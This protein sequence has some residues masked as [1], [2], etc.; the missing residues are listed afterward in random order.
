MVE[1]ESEQQ[2]QERELLENTVQNLQSKVRLY[3]SAEIC[4]KDE[5]STLQGQVRQQ[6]A[7]M[8]RKDEDLFNLQRQ[9]S[10]YERDV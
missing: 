6:E 7:Q 5:I 9:N 3:E 1:S 4:T 2:A 10:A 8:R